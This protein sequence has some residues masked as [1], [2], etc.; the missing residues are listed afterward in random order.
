MAASGRACFAVDHNGKVWAWGADRVG[1]NL[2][3]HP[4]AT[5]KVAVV[6]LTQIPGLCPMLH[7]HCNSNGTAVMLTEDGKAFGW[8]NNEQGQLQ[9]VKQHHVEAPTPLGI[10]FYVFDVA[11]ADE[12]VVA[13]VAKPNAAPPSLISPVLSRNTSQLS[14]ESSTSSTAADEKPAQPRSLQSTKGLPKYN[15]PVKK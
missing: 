5:D 9:G 15:R 2:L 12:F 6:A 8:G 3:P 14:Q 1:E 11:V 13:I 4:P 10:K 7:V